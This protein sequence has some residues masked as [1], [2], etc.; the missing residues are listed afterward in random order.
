M[1]E[2]NFLSF[3]QQVLTMVNPEDEA[4]IA[5]G[6]IALNAV[7]ELALSSRKVSG[8]VVRMMYGAENCF[9]QLIKNAAHFIGKPGEY[10]E[11]EQKRRRLANAIRP[12][13]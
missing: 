2:Q 9:D 1:S 7:I 13:C 12:G 6:K 4:S 8:P 11:N 3:L 5:L 10:I